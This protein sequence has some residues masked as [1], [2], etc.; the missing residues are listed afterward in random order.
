MVTVVREWK[1]AT[2]GHYEDV[3]YTDA[4]IEGVFGS[5]PNCLV[6]ALLRR[7]QSAEQ[8][9]AELLEQVK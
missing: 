3:E 6:I 1:P 2:E 8:Q 5:D 7:A 4:E 9:V